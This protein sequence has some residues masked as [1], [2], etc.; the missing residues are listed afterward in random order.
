VRTVHGIGYAFS[1]SATEIAP[2]PRGAAAC[3][4]V[5][6]GQR[7]PLGLGDHVIGR[8]A[9]AAVTLDSSTVSRRHACLRVTA[10]TATIRDLGSKN[11]T[12]LNDQR[13]EAES[14]V[15]DGDRLRLGSILMTFRR[16]GPGSATETRKSSQQG[17]DAAS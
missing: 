10:P 9:D 17:E 8:D 14:A 7:Y 15:A 16:P 5:W 13:V 3:V 4:L 1:G 12:F 11:G 6:E 2:A